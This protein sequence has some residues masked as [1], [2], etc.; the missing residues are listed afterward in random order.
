MWTHEGSRIGSG[1]RGYRRA[2]AA[3]LPMVTA[4]EINGNL[5]IDRPLAPFGRF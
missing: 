2:A 5:N 4:E 1:G 3:T